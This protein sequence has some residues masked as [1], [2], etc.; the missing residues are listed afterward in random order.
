MTI[1]Y[2]DPEI[3]LLDHWRIQ[4]GADRAAAPHGPNI[5]VFF[6]LNTK[7]FAP[8]CMKID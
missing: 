7:L 4:V 8:F 5:G 2:W 1:F 3:L 6:Y